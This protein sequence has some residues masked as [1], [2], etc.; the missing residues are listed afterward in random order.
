LARRAGLLVLGF[1]NV[2]RTLDGKVPPRLLVEA[3]DGA[4]DGRR[5]LQRAAASRGLDLAMVD[6]LSGAELSLALGRE[7]VIHA[8]VK[9]GPLAQRL[10]FDAARLKGFRVRPAADETAGSSPARNERNV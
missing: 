6:N 8:A 9:P 2:L 3:G 10:L 5:K 7:N 1:D 4:A